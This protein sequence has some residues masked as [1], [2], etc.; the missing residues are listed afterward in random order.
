MKDPYQLLSIFKENIILFL[1]K[2]W[3]KERVFTLLKPH[4]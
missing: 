4:Q 2:G 1:K 3:Y